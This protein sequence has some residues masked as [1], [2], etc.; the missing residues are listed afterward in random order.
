MGQCYS[1]ATDI[2]DEYIDG[3]LHP[4]ELI[5]IEPKEV[6]KFPFRKIYWARVLSVYDADTI[7]VMFKHDNTIFKYKLRI[8]GV[9]SPEI[10]GK[11]SQQY[12]DHAIKGRDY[13]R[14]LFLN[15]DTP[16]KCLF[17]ILPTDYDKFGQRL[18]GDI[19]VGVDCCMQKLSDILINRGFAAP[20]DGKTKLTE[21]QW[22][23]RINS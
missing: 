3:V 23:S 12:K 22:L 17:N 2:T 5:N 1:R 7:W 19:L 8:S 21:E 10:R 15:G 20:Y 14:S 9:D 11:Y 16:K 6:S 18:I 4:D 13:V